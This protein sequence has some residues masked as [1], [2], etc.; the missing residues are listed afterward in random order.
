MMIGGNH[1]RMGLTHT[2]KFILD[3]PLNR[4]RPAQAIGRFI[5]WQI[6]SRLLGSSAVVPFARR[7]RLIVRNGMTG[8]TQNIYCGLH[9]FHDMAFV[10]HM[11]RPGDLFVDIG[12]NVGTYTVLAAE[13]GAQCITFEPVP[14]TYQALSDNIYLNRIRERVELVN[15]AVGAEQGTIAFTLSGGPTNHVATATD[16][17]PVTEVPV[18]RLDDYLKR[19]PTVMKIDVEG[20][21]AVLLKGARRTLADPELLAVIME[22]NGSGTRY[23]YSDSEIRQVMC[24]AGFGEYCYA[25]MKRHLSPLGQT[26]PF[27]NVLFIKDIGRLEERLKS[28]EPV[29]INGRTF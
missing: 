16:R 27:D 22:V 11:I 12:A 8:A 1:R 28:A 18:V 10:L 13:S 21:E 14:E 9:E 24:E 20:Y 15:A 7:S 26:K 4:G 19:S 29:T 17:G 3:H 6:G 2:I 25:P 5:R 23:G